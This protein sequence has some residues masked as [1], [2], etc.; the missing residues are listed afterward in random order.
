MTGN[1]V[2]DA[3]TPGPWIASQYLDTDEWGILNK[4]NYIVVGLSSRITE[5]NARLIAA[6]PDLLAACTDALDLLDEDE[7]TLTQRELLRHTLLKAI[8]KARGE[9]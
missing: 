9:A 4:D 2:Q 3:A 5:A 7:P 6:A 1:I 8:A